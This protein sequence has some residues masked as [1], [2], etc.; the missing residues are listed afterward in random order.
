MF[1]MVC[2]KNIPGILG[3]QG[4][5]HFPCHCTFL[6]EKDLCEGTVAGNSC[7]HAACPRRCRPGRGGAAG[8]CGSQVAQSGPHCFI[9]PQSTLLHPIDATC[10]SIPAYSCCI[11]FSLVA[12]LFLV[13]H[14]CFILENGQQAY[15]E[16][17]FTANITTDGSTVSLRNLLWMYSTKCSERGLLQEYVV[18]VIHTLVKKMGLMYLYSFLKENNSSI[19]DIS[20]TGHPVAGPWS[21]HESILVHFVSCIQVKRFVPLLQPYHNKAIQKNKSCRSRPFVWKQN[22]NMYSAKSLVIISWI[23]HA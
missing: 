4:Q 18:C 2:K 15:E 1:G 20:Q 7:C 11:A 13:M 12:L 19:L 21:V 8:R 23:M 5:Y 14:F 22:P 16:V 6:C 9:S 17:F 3:I 10:C